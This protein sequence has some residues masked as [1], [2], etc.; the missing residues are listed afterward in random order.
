LKIFIKEIYTTGTAARRPGSSRRLPVRTV[1]NINDVEALV[2][3]Q[4]DNPQTYRMQ[5]QIK[6]ELGISKPS[7]NNIVKVGLFSISV[8]LRTYDNVSCKCGTNVIRASL[9]RQSSNDVA[10][11]LSACVAANGRQFE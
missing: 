10:R 2:L 3:N 11:R 6:H 8:I 9:M 1:D 5:K 7:V 4:E